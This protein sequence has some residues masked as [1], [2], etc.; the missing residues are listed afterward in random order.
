MSWHQQFFDPV[1]QPSGR[2]LVT[3]RD[4]A[5]Y[6]TKPLEAEQLAPEWQAAIEVLM[7][8]GE[9]GGDPM[10]ADIAMMRALQHKPEA[11]PAPPWKRAKAYRIVR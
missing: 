1:T 10:I 8:I 9:N 2:K 4:A 6:I 11:A 7:L 3:L 5:H